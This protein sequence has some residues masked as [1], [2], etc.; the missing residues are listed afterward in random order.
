MWRH[1]SFKQ[2]DVRHTPYTSHR[3]FGNL[4]QSYHSAKSDRTRRLFRWIETADH[5]LVL[6]H[7]FAMVSQG[8]DAVVLCAHDYR[9]L[10]QENGQLHL[11]WL[12]IIIRWS[13]GNG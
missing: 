11:N 5:S 1:Q 2:Q 7:G 4:T 6:L 13:F 9:N 12:R 8:H 3:V 10:A